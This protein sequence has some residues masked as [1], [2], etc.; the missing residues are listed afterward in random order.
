MSAKVIE[1]IEVKTTIGKG[2]VGNPYR[3]IIEYYTLDGKL[4]AHNDPCK[5]VKNE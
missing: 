3:E 2:V 1:V 5:E 4:I